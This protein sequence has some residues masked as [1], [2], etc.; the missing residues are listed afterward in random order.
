[1]NDWFSV[2]FHCCFYINNPSY[3]L[4]VFH[5]LLTKGILFQH[6]HLH[7]QSSQ[8]SGLAPIKQF[9][10]SKNKPHSEI[11]NFYVSLSFTWF[12]H[13]SGQVNQF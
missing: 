1:M 7:M 2:L 9:A 13:I 12:D 6:M 5:N 11:T 4:L 3:S 10:L 8:Q